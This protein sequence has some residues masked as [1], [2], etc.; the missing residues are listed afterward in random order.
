MS[1]EETTSE[2]DRLNGLEWSGY[3]RIDLNAPAR[4]SEF[5]TWSDWSSDENQSFTAQMLAEKKKDGQWQFK[6]QSSFQMKA[7]TCSDVP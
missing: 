6:N 4:S 3:I 7:I 2:A 1:S 5:K